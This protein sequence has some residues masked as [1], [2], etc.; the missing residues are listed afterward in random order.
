MS[1]KLWPDRSVVYIVRADDDF[2]PSSSW[3]CPETF[4]DAKV[5]VRNLPLED[6][7]AMVRGLN[8]VALASWQA[9]HDA[10]AANGR[11]QSHVPGPR[12]GT[13]RIR[14]PSITR[15]MQVAGSQAKE[16]AA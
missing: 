3:D 12:G 11:S 10:W 2:T 16:E 13:K 8:K 15:A 6:A 4:S 14:V 9:S 7:R 5:Q 1:K